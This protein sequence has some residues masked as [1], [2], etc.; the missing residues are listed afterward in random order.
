MDG[1]DALIKAPRLPRIFELETI[2]GD[3]LY[4][5]RGWNGVKQVDQE[6]FLEYVV[7]VASDLPMKWEY[8]GYVMAPQISLYISNYG[9]RKRLRFEETSPN[10]IPAARRL[11]CISHQAS[12]DRL[13]VRPSKCSHAASSGLRLISS[14]EPFVSSAIFQSS[15]M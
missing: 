14:I 13:A 8:P 9:V 10:T 2:H 7:E 4:L 15:R 1:R 5:A 11:W 12:I 6:K 3:A